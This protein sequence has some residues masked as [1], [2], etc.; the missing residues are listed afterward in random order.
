VWF[1]RI[2]GHYTEKLYILVVVYYSFGLIH[3]ITIICGFFVA[4]LV[5]AGVFENIVE[6]KIF[7]F[8]TSAVSLIIKTQY[9]DGF[10]FLV[11]SQF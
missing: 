2:L 3:P 9:V 7:M 10:K 11:S 4:F 1:E 5:I 6:C 8:V